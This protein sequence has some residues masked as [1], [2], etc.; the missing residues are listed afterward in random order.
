MADELT[1]AVEAGKVVLGLTQTLKFLRSG[2]AAKV[3]YANNIPDKLKKDVLYY[4]GLA[5]VS[6]ERFSGSN[7]ELGVKCKR[8]HSVLVMAIIK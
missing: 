1:K 3:V 7:L 8:A 2:K 5:K 4:S 6:T